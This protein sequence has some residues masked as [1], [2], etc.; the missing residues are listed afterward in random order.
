MGQWF[1]FIDLS[2]S[3]CTELTNNVCFAVS[4][5]NITDRPVIGVLLQPR[6]VGCEGPDVNHNVGEFEMIP[7]NNYFEFLNCRGTPKVTFNTKYQ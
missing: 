3:L 7:T 1:Q 4:V 6:L 5:E 2:H